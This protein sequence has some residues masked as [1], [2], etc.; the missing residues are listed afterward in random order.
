MFRGSILQH[1]T[2]RYI[3]RKRKT[4]A[5]AKYALTIPRLIVHRSLAHISAQIVDL[6]GNILAS[7]TDTG[8]SGTKSDKA[9]AVGKQL[10]SQAVAAGVTT[11]VFDRNGYTYH[12]RVQQL[13]AGA[14]EAGLVF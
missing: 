9:F 14:R 11:L 8:M 2:K 6:Q 12:G 5:V 10:G 4:N 1:K 13:A 7:A 3:A